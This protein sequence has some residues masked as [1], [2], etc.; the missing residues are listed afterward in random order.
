MR[1]HL[2]LI[3]ILAVG[4]SVMSM[5]TAAAQDKVKLKLG[6]YLKGTITAK[7][8]EV[9]YS[10]SGK[11]GD[12]V[13]LEIVPD[14]QTGD[15][16]PTVELRDSNGQSLAINDGFSFP[17]TLAIA[18]LPA[19]G[20]YIAVAGRSGGEA[21]D[22]TGDYM[23]RVSIAKLVAAGSTID[24]KVSSSASAPPQIYVMHPDKATTLT[25]DFTQQPTID[26]FTAIGILK[27]MDD[28]YSVPVMNMDNTNKLTKA[29]LTVDLEAGAFYVIKIVQGDYSLNDP[30]DFPVTLTLK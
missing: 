8:Y 17:L 7:V 25:V 2:W 16:D 21:G 23:L 24:T 22:T 19:D 29:T 26:Y 5:G 3:P 4:L 18:E 11:K 30:V 12:V 1:K 6:E 27:Y 13:T 28:A 9:G 10:F 14:Q 20:D 15:L